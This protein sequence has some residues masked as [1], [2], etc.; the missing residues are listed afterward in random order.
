M[1]NRLNGSEIRFYHY[2]FKLKAVWLNLPLLF[3][4]F[5]NSLRNYLVILV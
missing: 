5:L 3:T 4:N 2:H 1:D